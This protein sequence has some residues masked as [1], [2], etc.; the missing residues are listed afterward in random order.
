[1]LYQD[2]IH[3]VTVVSQDSFQ[4][5]CHKPYCPPTSVMWP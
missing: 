2:Y 3:K 5:E 4:R 1:M